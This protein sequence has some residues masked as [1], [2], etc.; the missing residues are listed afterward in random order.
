MIPEQPA[1]KVWAEAKRTALISSLI[2][3]ALEGRKPT[4]HCPCLL[5]NGIRRIAPGLK[6]K[7]M[8]NQSNT[9]KAP[10]NTS[11]VKYLREGNPAGST[12]LIKK[13]LTRSSG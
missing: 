13:P 11:L 12:R 8:A 6:V 4:S 1:L 9:T 3:G 2:G 5:A 10:V 7:V